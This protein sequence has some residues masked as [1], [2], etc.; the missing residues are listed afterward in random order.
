M[1]TTLA[2]L[3]M[4]GHLIFSILDYVVA[5]IVVY[6]YLFFYRYLI[7]ISFKCLQVCCWCLKLHS[8]GIFFIFISVSVGCRLLHNTFCRRNRLYRRWWF[9]FT[10]LAC[11]K[12]INVIKNTR[13]EKIIRMSS[14]IEWC[15]DC[16]PMPHRNTYRLHLSY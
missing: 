10:K 5:C 16:I 12:I 14:F 11:I 15:Y 7:I 9:C 6:I 1:S 2:S 4:K 13:D 8:S 3:G